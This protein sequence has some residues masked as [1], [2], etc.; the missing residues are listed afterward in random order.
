MAERP[1]A[2][3]RRS[4]VR[5]LTVSDDHARVQVLCRMRRSPSKAPRAALDHLVD[6]L[7]TP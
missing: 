1:S 5:D 2:A 4:T 7:V 6:D 3:R